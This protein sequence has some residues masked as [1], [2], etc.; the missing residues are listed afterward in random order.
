MLGRRSPAC[1][2]PRNTPETMRSR[3]RS[4]TTEPAACS[5]DIPTPPGESLREDVCGSCKKGS[6]RALPSN[7]SHCLF[8]LCLALLPSSVYAQLDTTGLR[9]Q[10]KRAALEYERS[11][12]RLAPQRPP[13]LS[14]P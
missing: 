10:L 13:G 9:S 1:Q 8:V 6:T 12:R 7:L 3:K 4:T 14:R 11:I 5:R 2:D